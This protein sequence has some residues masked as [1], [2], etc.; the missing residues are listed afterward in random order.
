LQPSKVSYMWQL[1]LPFALLPV[2]SPRY[3]VLATPAL[4]LNLLSNFSQQQTLIFH[5]NALIVPVAAV[6]CIKAIVWFIERVSFQRFMIVGSAVL[7][8]SC[9]TYALATSYSRFEQYY[10][11][12]DKGAARISLYN[13][14]LS[15]V[16]A[17]ANISAQSDLQ[18]HLA[19]RLQAFVFPNPFQQ[20]AF[21]N[22]AGLPFTPRIDYIV[23]DMRRADNFYAPAKAKLRLLADLQSRGLYQ[24]I[25]DLDGIVL[26]RRSDTSLEERCFGMNWNAPQCQVRR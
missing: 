15:L 9:S 21:S 14:V 11:R 19:H 10:A 3:L 6:A 16:P 8:I 5:Y 22:P 2:L 26:L 12:S 18:P 1:L 24:P 23:Y 7:I 17:E 13:Y 25:V 4:L 20:V